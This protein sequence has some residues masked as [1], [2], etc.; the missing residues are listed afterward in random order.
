VGTLLA[1]AAR[2]A[3]LTARTRGR[4][5]DPYWANLA[6]AARTSAQCL[7]AGD[8]FL[9]RSPSSFRGAATTRFLPTALIVRRLRAGSACRHAK[10]GGE[11]RW[12]R[13]VDLV[14]PRVPC[15][16]Q[17]DSSHSS[18]LRLPLHRLLVVCNELNG[19][20]AP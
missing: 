15:Q 4:S 7:L 11:L 3:A 2:R 14:F 12:R 18:R 9:G 6:C 10:L 16:P 20:T 19:A 5:N 17:R 1:L 13:N 8:C